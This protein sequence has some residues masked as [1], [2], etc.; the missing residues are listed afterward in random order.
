MP[1]QN[2]KWNVSQGNYIQMPINYIMKADV[3]QLSVKVSVHWGLQ[4][5][6]YHSEK[7]LASLHRDIFIF[8]ARKLGG[9]VKETKD[10]RDRIRQ[11]SRALIPQGM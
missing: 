3:L 5:R 6:Q 1:G 2:R 4:F 9:G 10:N 11:R 7:I 8:S